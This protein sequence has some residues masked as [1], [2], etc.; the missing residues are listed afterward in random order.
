M[1][2]ILLVGKFNAAFETLNRDLSQFFQVQLSSDSTELVKNLLD[3]NEPDLV[4][5]CLIGLTH[6][7]TAIMN[8]LKFYHSSIPV[9]CVGT[10]A[11]QSRFI[12]FFKDEQFSVI[13]RPVPNADIISK[14]AEILQVPVNRAELMLMQ[15][16]QKRKC[17]LVV[18]DN[19]IQLRALKDMLT[20][21]NYDVLMANS[22]SK[23]IGHIGKRV[24]DLIILDYEMPICD[25]R[26]TLEMIREIEEAKEIP[27]VFLT[28]V[29]DTQHIQA[30]VKLKPAAYI[31]KPASQDT[32]I[33]TVSSI[34]GE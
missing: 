12:G 6:E 10:E 11:E 22:G 1:K 13:E 7:H 29:N 30:V 20:P 21:R 19:A 17:I 31:L 33:E 32:I 16:E 23:A 24:P 14:I 15:T 9:V 3:I 5:I 34:L 27:V 28:G 26:Q 18:D 25:G 8:L 4:V 2:H